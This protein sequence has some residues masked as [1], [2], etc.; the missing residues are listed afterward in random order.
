MRVTLDGDHFELTP[1]LVRAKL[2]GHAP[3][4]IRHHW[5]EIDGTRWPVKQVI[6]LATGVG[7]RGRFQSQSSR[8]WLSNLG[9]ACGSGREGVL[10]S[11]RSVPSNP[12][13][14]ESRLAAELPDRDLVLVGCV[15]SKRAFGAPAKDLYT[16]D[17]F[18]KMRT[19]AEATGLPW[20]ILS[21]EHGLV[22]PDEW[23]EPY[24]RYLP[25]TSDDYRRAWGLKV[26]T[27]LEE[28]VGPLAGLVVDVHAGGVYVGSV[29]GPLQQRG[30]KVIDQLSGLSFGRRLSWYLKR[31]GADPAD[32]R[33]VVSE[34]RDR[35][36]ART[37]SA[38]LETGGAGLRAPGLY[39]W[40]VDAEGAADLSSGLGYPLGPGLIYAGLAGRLAV[41]VRRPG[42]RS[43][44]E[45]PPCTSARRTTFPRC[46]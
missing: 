33:G 2:R 44:G 28:A 27:Q 41:A 18:V 14:S 36:S 5:V 17:Y 11:G 6:S 13:V 43:G 9:F 12:R 30:A 8:R 3:E 38:V 21:A 10:D 40:W 24:E 45:S 7:D 42:T 31:E 37:L 1:E 15:K 29:R 25:E 4:P 23:L 35:E 34:L 46:G 39:S 20:F 22:R 16:S 26:A 32:A 19:Y